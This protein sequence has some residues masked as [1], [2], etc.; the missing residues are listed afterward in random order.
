MSLILAALSQRIP[1]SVRIL[2]DSHSTRGC[3]ETDDLYIR[4]FEGKQVLVI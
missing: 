3:D 2:L 1:A 4:T